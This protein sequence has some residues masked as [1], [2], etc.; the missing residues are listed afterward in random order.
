MELTKKEAKRLSILKWEFII[1]NGG[2]Y[3]LHKLPKELE[4]LQSECG[5][6]E[7][8]Y[9]K[10][11]AG[12]PINTPDIG[13]CWHSGHLFHVWYNNK[14]VENAQAVLDLIKKS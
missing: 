8:Y 14:T 7:K 5:Y 10:N 11:C 6:C 1:E 3:K 2:N 12:C 13:K 9:E 4:N